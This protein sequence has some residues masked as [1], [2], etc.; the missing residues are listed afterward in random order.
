MNSITFTKHYIGCDNVCQ[1]M[2]VVVRVRKDLPVSFFQTVSQFLLAV[3]CPQLY[4]LSYCF[5]SVSALPCIIGADIQHCDQTVPKLTYRWVYGHLVHC[6]ITCPGCVSDGSGSPH[7]VLLWADRQVTRVK[8]PRGENRLISWSGECVT[9]ALCNPGCHPLKIWPQYTDKS[10][11]SEKI[12]SASR[13]F[14]TR[15]PKFH[16]H[17]CRLSPECCTA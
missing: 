5:F 9:V 8:I 16:N 11:R 2:W 14:E 3:I 7:T 15:P 13:K 4:I 10:E 12:L 17:G 6:H 1:F